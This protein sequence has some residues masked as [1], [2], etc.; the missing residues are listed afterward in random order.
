[1]HAFSNN[2]L[3]NLQTSLSCNTVLNNDP[4][5]IADDNLDSEAVYISFQHVKLVDNII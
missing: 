4:C 3:I 2:E 5:H 1:M